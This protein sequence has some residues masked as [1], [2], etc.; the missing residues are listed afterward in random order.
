MSYL[1][2]KLA[3]EQ[4]KPGVRKENARQNNVDNIDNWRN[5]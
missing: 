5:G 4:M 2:L 1:I 3:E